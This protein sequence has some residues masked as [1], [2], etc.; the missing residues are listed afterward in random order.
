MKEYDSR[1]LVGLLLPPVLS[2]GAY[3]A[4]S[5]GVLSIL[6][7]LLMSERLDEMWKRILSVSLVVIAV[8]VLHVVQ[9]ND[10]FQDMSSTTGVLIVGLFMPVSLLVSSGIWLM[11]SPRRYFTRLSASVSFPVVIGCFIVLWLLGES[12]SS[13]ETLRIYQEVLDSVIQMLMGTQMVGADI[14]TMSGFVNDMIIRFGLFIY[15][16]QFLAAV[17]ISEIFLHRNSPSFE[18]RMMR[19]RVPH[20]VLWIF[21]GAFALV[22]VTFFTESTL[23]EIIAYN[24]SSVLA[25][26]YAVHGVSIAVYLL[27]RKLEHIRILR[28]FNFSLMLM[29]LPGI[30]VIAFLGF[31]LL[32]ISETWVTYRKHE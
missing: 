1:L 22:L 9:L 27:N 5:S 14:R 24:I 15:L 18:Q 21:L 11:L 4:T 25:L 12:E 19:W 28:T 29:A 26:L 2:F 30:N 32:G 17:Y 6:P 31:A 10:I 16:V 23:V 20:E 7:L 8:I 13:K 3:L